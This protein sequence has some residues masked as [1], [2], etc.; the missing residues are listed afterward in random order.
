MRTL[1][2]HFDGKN[3]V[4]DELARLKP[5]TKVHVVVPEEDG[6]TATELIE[7][8]ARLSEPAFRTIWDTPLDADYDGRG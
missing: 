3:I 7:S 5:N 8:C 6:E 4:L 1:R 2:A